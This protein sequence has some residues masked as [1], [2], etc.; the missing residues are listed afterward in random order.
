VLKKVCEGRLKK[1]KVKVKLNTAA[2]YK[3]FDKY[4]H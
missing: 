4:D 3:D 1:N 2:T